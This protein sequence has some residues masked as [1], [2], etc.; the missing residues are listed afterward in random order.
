VHE[1]SIAKGTLLG[2]RKQYDKYVDSKY[3]REQCRQQ[4]AGRKAAHREYEE[5]IVTYVNDMHQA[6]T[7]VTKRGIVYYCRWRFRM[8]NAVSYEA[9]MMWVERFVKRSNLICHVLKRAENVEDVVAHVLHDVLNQIIA[10]PTYDTCI[11]EPSIDVG[12]KQHV[13]RE[14][15]DDV[16]EDS[17]GEIYQVYARPSDYKSPPRKLR[18]R[19]EPETTN[20]I[21]QFAFPN[22]ESYDQGPERIIHVST[23]DLNMLDDGE[24]IGDVC[25]SYYLKRYLPQHEA[26]YVFTSQTWS[27]LHA[28]QIELDAGLPCPFYGCVTSKFNWSKYRFVVFPIHGSSHWSLAVLENPMATPTSIYH[29]DSIPGYHRSNLVANVLMK[30]LCI[31]AKRTSSFN[32][33]DNTQVRSVVPN[34]L[35][36]NSFDC[37]VYVML[38]AQ[39]IASY[40][41]A[42]DPPT[43][44]PVIQDLVQGCT[45]TTCQTMR[46]TVRALIVADSR[47]M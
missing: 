43:L 10:E 44:G 35:Q 27:A 40:I 8:F 25:I 30:H 42:E 37:G 41:T 11:S 19:Q 24:W 33:P 38:Y 9:S 15:L 18:R 47:I 12:D 34:D 14:V 21:C 22:E 4:G 2:W 17:D 39:K 45:R 6:G 31:Q 32:H 7:P 16:S 3:R 46:K 1:L 23:V 20:V 29:F 26:L 5:D 28:Q 36:K 13:K